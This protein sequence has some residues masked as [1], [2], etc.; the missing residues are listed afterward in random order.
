[1]VERYG[2]LGPSCADPTTL[3]SMFAE[4]MTGIRLNTSH[5]SVRDAAEQLTIVREAAAAC[6]VQ[7]RLLIDMQGP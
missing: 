7:A 5:I 4:G 1:M 3:R 2:T 6:G